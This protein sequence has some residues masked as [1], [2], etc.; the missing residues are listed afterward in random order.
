[1]DY[2]KLEQ[3]LKQLRFPDRVPALSFNPQ[4]PPRAIL[5]R[6]N[7]LALAAGIA[8]LALV[9]GL[10]LWSRQ[11][12]SELQAPPVSETPSV[13]EPS[14]E[15]E[16]PSES[17]PIEST[18]E[19]SQAEES[20]AESTPS[21]EDPVKSTEPTESVESVETAPPSQEEPPKVLPDKAEIIR[22][23]PSETFIYQTGDWVYYHKSER[24]TWYC[25]NIKTGQE[26]AFEI[27][28]RRYDTRVLLSTE[29]WIYC[30]D[31]YM[32]VEPT[33]S[34]EKL[35]RIKKDGSEVQELKGTFGVETHGNQMPKLWGDWIY[36][37]SR[38]NLCRISVKDNTCETVVDLGISGFDFQVC[39][40]GIFVHKSRWN[41]REDQIIR[42][43]LDGKN[44]TVLWEETRFPPQILFC[45][46]DYVYLEKTSET[47]TKDPANQSGTNDTQK[48]ELW[49]MRF[50]G[51]ERQR[52]VLED[53]IGSQFAHNEEWI[54]YTV[55]DEEKGKT[56]VRRTR[57]DGSE[58]KTVAEP[59][60]ALFQA[61]EIHG[62][63]LYFKA[64]DSL[65]RT[66]LD[67]SNP[68]V[69]Y[70]YKG[71]DHSFKSFIVK[72]DVPYVV[73]DEYLV[74]S[75]PS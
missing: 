55:S 43:D 41:P 50:D 3:N 45:G 38:S 37:I 21:Q 9:V 52:I 47:E 59:S 60:T 65:T 64:I 69:L 2:D 71:G 26:R 34:L 73:L 40:K 44:P 23:E 66:E 16:P 27:P 18:E 31:G 56:I 48:T 61:L 62:D 22:L 32:V 20:A 39:D 57:L 6:N 15:T 72:D 49:R 67:G 51:T 17:D 63:F 24:N 14:V 58:T 46:G 5:I 13:T 10:A 28:E 42:Y 54:Y 36:F 74:T 68:V 8:C 53:E 30:T 11:W 75:M 35:F 29:D 4:E 1:M 33:E 70:D 19:S 25:R 7:L 12:K